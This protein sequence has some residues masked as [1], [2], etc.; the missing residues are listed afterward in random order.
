M[1][2][3]RLYVVLPL[4][5]MIAGCGPKPYDREHPAVAP[6]ANPTTAIRLVDVAKEHPAPHAVI[7]LDKATLRRT[8]TISPP[9]EPLHSATTAS[10]RTPR[11]FPPSRKW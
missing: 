8:P 1:L 5:G 6:S 9:S 3:K 7:N 10:K 4:A 11:Q 2:S